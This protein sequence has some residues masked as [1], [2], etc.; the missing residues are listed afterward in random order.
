MSLEHL[1]FPSGL[2]GTN[3]ALVW[4]TRTREGV[5]IDP[6]GEPEEIMD[7]ALEH[8]IAI[9]GIALT[10]A[11]F[12]H[13]AAV[14]LLKELTQADLYVHPLDLPLWEGME[15]QCNHFGLPPFSLPEPDLMLEEG[16]SI[17]FGRQ[18]LAVMHLPGHSPGS[19]GFLACEPSL[20]FC[21]DVAF[22]RGVGRTD[23]WG[24]SDAALQ[25]SLVRLR[26]LPDTIEIIPGHG[27]T[28]RASSI[29]VRAQTLNDY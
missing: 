21:G 27:A 7:I 1:V 5:L 18:K 29:G 11:H 20:L 2:L 9:R 19:C 26:A 17:E 8:G 3:T 25:S 12:D 16:G 24:G 6:A 14:P 15:G 22:A 10:H 28:F 4:C 13:A 23:L